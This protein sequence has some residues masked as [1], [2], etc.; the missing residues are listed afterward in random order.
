MKPIEI[1]VE[2]VSD[3]D[4][5]NKP[6]MDAHVTVACLTLAWHSVLR[7]DP[8]KRADT[9]EQIEPALESAT[10][11]REKLKSASKP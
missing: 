9:V 1:A 7:I 10:R 4:A 6:F 11:L 5:A 2:P 3:A 8:L